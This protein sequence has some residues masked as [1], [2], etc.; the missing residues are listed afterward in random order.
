MDVPQQTANEWW[1]T[2]AILFAW[3]E[4]ATD[5]LPKFIKINDITVTFVPM[6]QNL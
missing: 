6:I 3:K 1:Q 5:H 2:E 4:L